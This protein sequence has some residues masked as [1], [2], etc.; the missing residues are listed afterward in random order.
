MSKPRYEPNSAG[1]EEV[2]RGAGTQSLVQSHGNALAS[3]A[4]D[5]F[6]AS[7]Q[8]GRSRYRGI[9]YA[10]TWSAKHREARGNILARV[11]G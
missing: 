4:G 5:G 1:L 11:L 6:V 8:Q 2:L 3:A 9:V 7:F 10:D